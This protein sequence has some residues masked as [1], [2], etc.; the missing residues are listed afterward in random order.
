MD[1]N[2]ENSLDELEYKIQKI[3]TSTNVSGDK[4]KHYIGQ[5]NT[6]KS[7]NNEVLTLQVDK[8]IWFR[9]KLSEFYT[10]DSKI[11]ASDMVIDKFMIDKFMIDKLNNKGSFTNINGYCED[12]H[13]SIDNYVGIYDDGKRFALGVRGDK[14]YNECIKIIIK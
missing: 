2:I 11:R 13:I 3:L 6:L 1:I 9:N 7:N 12:Y 14:L 8:K 5:Y 4:L 10:S